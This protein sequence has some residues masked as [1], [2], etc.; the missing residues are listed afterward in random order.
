[1]AMLCRIGTAV[2]AFVG[3]I[4]ATS[5]HAWTNNLYW[6]YGWWFRLGGLVIRAVLEF[7]RCTDLTSATSAG[8]RRLRWRLA[9]M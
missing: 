1:M 6:N 3:I 5:V 9:T 8:I 4:G 7:L 2:L